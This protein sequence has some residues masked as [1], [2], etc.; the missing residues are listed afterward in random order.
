MEVT[1]LPMHT[2]GARSVR[3]K[4]LSEA[5]ELREQGTFQLRSC[6]VCN[7][8]HAHLHGADGPLF[9][10]LDCSRWYFKG[11]DLTSLEKELVP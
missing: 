7:P 8:A 3:E 4:L 2:Q 1:D 5:L 9:M 6:Q 11:V 10:C